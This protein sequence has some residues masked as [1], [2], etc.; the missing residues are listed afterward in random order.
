MTSRAAIYGRMSTDKQ[1]PKSAEDQLREARAFAAKHGWNVVAEF[2]DEGISGTKAKR[3]PGFQ[4]LLAAIR[5]REFDVLVIE[6]PD[7]LARDQAHTLNAI[8]L[9][10]HYAVRVVAYSGVYDS[11]QPGSDA[12]LFAL[13]F[14]AAQQVSAGSAKTHRGLKS[15][16]EEGHSA[17][18]RAYGYSSVPVYSGALDRY[19][20]K[21]IAAY[22]K[23]INE[24]RAKIVREIFRQYA[25]GASPRAIANDR[26]A[27][28]G[29]RRPGR[30]EDPGVA[31]CE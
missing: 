29:I 23:V 19:G 7:R 21:E 10:K 11:E 5:A 16:V 9:C 20:N 24:D 12:Q 8:K 4:S 2:K 25:D 31:D 6:H 13:G 17:G 15:K 28:T 27:A 30:E 18:G 22:R 3:R 14:V 1:N 26:S